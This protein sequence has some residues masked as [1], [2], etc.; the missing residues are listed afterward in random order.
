V[1]VLLSVWLRPLKAP[2]QP[3]IAGD[4]LGYY[5]YLPAKFIHN[6]PQLDF[7]WF[8]NVYAANYSVSS[9]D[10]PEDN[11][12]VNFNGKRINKYYSGLS[13]I[14]LPFFVLGHTLAKLF[15]YPPDGFSAPYQWAMG[16]ASLFYLVLG[17]LFLRGLLYK[18]FHLKWL[19]T[20]IPLLYFFGTHLFSYAIFSNTLSHVYSFCFSTGFLYYTL[21]FFRDPQY[22]TRQ[23]F[24]AVLFLVIG[25]C[26]RPLNILLFFA[27]PAL[28]PKS[29]SWRTT[30]LEKI[31]VFH[32]LIALLTL[33]ALAWQVHVSVVQTQQ[34]LPYTYTDEHFD[35]GKARFFDALWSYHQGIFLYVPLI[36]FSVVGFLFFE[37]K[38]GWILLSVFAGIIFL[39]S[40]W[41]Y[42]PVM[43]RVLIDWYA[44]PAIGLAALLAAT[45]NKLLRAAVLTLLFIS[46]GYFQ[47]KAYQVQQGILDEYLTDKALYWRH[48][49]RVRPANNFAIPEKS[50][51]E[52]VSLEENFEVQKPGVKGS[53]A[54]AYEGKQSMVLDSTSFIS[55][56]QNFSYPALFRG[57]ELRKMRVGLEMYAGKGVE[58]AQVLIKILSPSNRELLLFPFYLDAAHLPQEQWDYKEFGFT[59]PDTT[60]LPPDSV[61]V[62]QVLIWNVHPAKPIYVDALQTD[63]ILTDTYFETIK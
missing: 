52:K 48:F 45:K 7:K 19:A 24:L 18:L 25:V 53:T 49:W 22:K 5:A 9:F 30:V 59:F 55:T 63:F 57:Q 44:I 21:S 20:L 26:I 50:I 62:I 2:G 13:Y 40:A 27:V 36:L 29:F 16:L 58:E 61:N 17:L 42:W 39:Y 12:L 28:I 56:V 47:L 38:A 51:R 3:F 8:N 11:F 54:I 60:Q 10:N 23:L 46:V 15:H 4:G 32:L 6:D 31:N 1:V 43:K 41:W 35:F 14:W 34:V 33:G 37:R